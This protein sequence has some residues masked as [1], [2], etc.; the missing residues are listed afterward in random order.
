M[1]TI[2]AV[3][4]CEILDSR[5]NPTIEVE[6][7]TQ[8]GVVGIGSVPSGAST[9]EAEAWELRDGDPARFGGKGVTKVVANVN[10]EIA[11]AVI[12]LDASDQRALDRTLI[13]LDGT[14]TRGVWARTPSSECPW[15][16]F[17][18]PPSPRGFPCTA[19]SA[20]RMD[21]SSPSPA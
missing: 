2:T 3:H 1:S 11:K 21:I 9:G 15:P 7:T 12:G 20:A 16:R 4:A 8:D 17:M 5:G 19:T 18:R 10:G 14:P 6:L 13:D